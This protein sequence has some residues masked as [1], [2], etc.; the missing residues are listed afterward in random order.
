MKAKGYFDY[1][2]A[3]PLDEGVF[4]V[5]MPYYQDLFYNPSS[6]TAQSSVVRKDIDNARAD[7]ADSLGVKA[8]EIIF[9]SGCTEA[10]NL[11]IH[12]VMSR[13]PQSKVLISAV[14][15][16]SIREIAH[17]FN[18][19]VVPVRESGIVDLDKLERLLTDDV[20]L[21]SVMYANNE[22]GTIQPLREIGLLISEARKRRGTGGAPLYLHT[23]A[24][25]AANYLSLIASGLRVDM[26]SL[27]SGK[28]YGPKGVGCL[29]VAGSVVL[30]PL[31]Y[32]GGQE[33]GLRS[34]TENVAGIIGFSWALKQTQKMRVEESIRLKILQKNLIVGLEALG[35]KVN[36]TKNKRIPN[37]VNVHFPGI[38]N[39]RLV[40]QLD[41][42]GFMVSSGSA[43]HAKSGTS[44]YSLQAIG[45]SQSDADSSIRIT[46]GRGT[47]LEDVENLAETISQLVAKNR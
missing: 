12:G 24:T 34:G 41:A 21:V 7:V 39:E 31:Q 27:N 29:F 42:H 14:E 6:F 37:N 26:M 46:M 13:N 2:S 40:L 15:H 32:G 45:L 16:D 22:I 38:D 11:A 9:T 18:Y 25:Q 1:A 33:R 10:N 20:V 19:D 5:M 17:Q 23:D 28:I 8:Q 3:T 30:N 36:G 44:S 43:C 4:D 47:T 35:A